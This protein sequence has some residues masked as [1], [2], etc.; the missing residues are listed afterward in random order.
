MLV[1]IRGQSPIIAGV[2]LTAAT[3]SWTAGSWLQAQLASRQGRRLL[4]TLGLFLLAFGLAGIASVLYAQPRCTG[5]GLCRLAR[6]RLGLNAAFFGAWISHWNRFC[7]KLVALSRQK[8]ATIAWKAE[9]HK[10]AARLV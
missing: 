4:V 5:N 3:L 9:C 10:I 6:L 1:S 8:H 2:V 7:G